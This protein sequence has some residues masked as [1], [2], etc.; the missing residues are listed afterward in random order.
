[1]NLATA[2]W[3]P[4]AGYGETGLTFRESTTDVGSAFCAPHLFH[5]QSS[6]LFIRM[7]ASERPKDSVALN[8][9]FMTDLARP[10]CIGGRLSANLN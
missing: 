10:V 7:S 5:D 9:D 4:H 1:M 3:A 6:R 8:K 2:R